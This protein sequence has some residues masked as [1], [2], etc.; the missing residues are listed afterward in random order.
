ML[1][2]FMKVQNLSLEDVKEVRP[3]GVGNNARWREEQLMNHRTT[4]LATV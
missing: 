4:L 2:P 1:L 3:G